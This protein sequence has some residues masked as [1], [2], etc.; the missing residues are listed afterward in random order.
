M[1]IDYTMG[2][3]VSY[4][5]LGPDGSVHKEGYFW[6]RE[7]HG[8][9]LNGVDLAK[10][11]ETFGQSIDMVPGEDGINLLQFTSKPL[12]V[13]ELEIAV[14]LYAPN[15]NGEPVLKSPESVDV[16]RFIAEKSYV[17][18]TASLGY[19]QRE[20]EPT[21]DRRSLWQRIRSSPR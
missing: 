14:L 11:R 19:A 12:N 10:G 5:Y 16:V 4:S 21:R 9:A 17:P 13:S 15:A 18:P 2:D 8:T 7:T 6:I 20:K 3:L 1:E